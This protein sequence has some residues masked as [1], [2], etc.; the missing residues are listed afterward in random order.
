MFVY[1]TVL[2]WPLSM[3]LWNFE[4]LKPSTL[5]KGVLNMIEQNNCQE[6]FG[7]KKSYSS[8]DFKQGTSAYNYNVLSMNCEEDWKVSDHCSIQVVL[9]PLEIILE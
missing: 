9:S 8:G 3:K 1:V 6:D 5:E 4:T 2:T 7:C